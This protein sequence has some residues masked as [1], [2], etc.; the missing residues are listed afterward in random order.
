MQLISIV[1]PAYNCEKYIAQAIDSMLQQTYTNFELL[2]ADDCSSDDTRKIIEAYKAKD[3]RIKTFHNET[4]QGYLRASNLLFEKC[5]GSFI[6][7][8]DADDWSDLKRLEKLLCAFEK[9]KDLF[10][11]GSWVNKVDEN[12]IAVSSIQFQTSHH[13]IQKA[14]PGKFECVGSAL[15]VKRDVIRKCGT[16]HYYFD[17]I[18]SEDLYWFG[19]I[20]H[21]FKTENLQEFLYNYRSTPGSVSNELNMPVRKR[22]SKEIASE[23]LRYYY[24]SGKELFDSRFNLRQIEKFVHGKYLCWD[25]QYKKGLLYLVQVLFSLPS[26][27]A[28]TFVLLKTYG[29]KLVR[30]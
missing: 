12:G 3:T 4:N 14:L 22:A 10:C 24:K 8:Q 30:S 20:A 1:M 23:A 21:H 2:I 17:R 25:K 15:M 9:D 6:T 7:F 28:E 26:R 11:V 13:E 18:G 27:A 5:N 16:Y 29:P 19:K